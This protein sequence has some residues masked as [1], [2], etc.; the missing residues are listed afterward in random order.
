MGGWA[1]PFAPRRDRT[2]LGTIARLQRELATR[3]AEIDALRGDVVNLEQQLAAVGGKH[4]TCCAP[5]RRMG[6]TA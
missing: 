6:A 4:C 2:M 3:D 1:Q 5:F